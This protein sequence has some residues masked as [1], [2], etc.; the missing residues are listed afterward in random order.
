MPISFTPDGRLLFSEDVPNHGRDIHLLWLDGSHKVESLVHSPARDATAEVSPDGR[1]LA[2]D[3]DESGQFEVYVRPFPDAARARWQVSVGGGRQPLWSRDGRELFYRDYSGN[4][5]SMPVVLTPTFRAG[6]PR[7]LF[8]GAG[9][10]GAGRFMSGRTYD[11][12]RDGRRFLMLKYQPSASPSIVVV[13][14][15]TEDLK[16]LVPIH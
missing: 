14:N 16:R 3:S 1:W 12:S 8:D 10:A 13:L 2:H 7:K 9:Y 5:L 15:W 6:P 11:I 4:L